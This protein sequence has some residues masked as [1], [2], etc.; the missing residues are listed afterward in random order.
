M[1]AGPAADVRARAHGTMKRRWLTTFAVNIATRSLRSES[2]TMRS[3]NSPRSTSAAAKALI[4]LAIA[5]TVLV[6]L[7]HVLSAA[8]ATLNNFANLL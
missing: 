2:L 1:S 3:P 4:A 8:A 7:A 6:V 5:G